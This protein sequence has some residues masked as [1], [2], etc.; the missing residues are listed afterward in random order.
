MH[1]LLECSLNYFVTTDSGWFYFK[2][3]ASN[4]NADIEDTQLGYQ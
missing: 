3:E 4:F 1:N 2:D